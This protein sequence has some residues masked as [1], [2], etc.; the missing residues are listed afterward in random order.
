V[1]VSNVDEGGHGET[2]PL[3]RAADLARLKAQ[4]IASRRKG[5]VVI[6]CDTLVVD[7]KGA[8]LEKPLDEREARGMIEAQSGGMSTVHSAL[9]VI[10]AEGRSHEG[11]SSST[12]T[13]K[14]LSEEEVQ[15]WLNTGLWR[16]R[17]GAFQIDGEGQLMI[18]RIEGDWTGVVGLPVFLL[19]QL[20]KE[21]GWSAWR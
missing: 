14:K 7:P 16:G 6:G 18:S 21:A 10:D 20:L 12:V 1:E 19:G 5:C 13:F 11:V 15:W 4:D 2:D 3:R 8:L 17:S 9:C